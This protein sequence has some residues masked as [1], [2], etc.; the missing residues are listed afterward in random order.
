MKE[1]PESS[2]SEPLKQENLELTKAITT[3]A[4]VE[5]DEFEATLKTHPNAPQVIASFAQTTVSSEYSGPIPPPH[6]LEQYSRIDPNLVAHIITG[7][8]EE[9]HHRHSCEKAI[10][11]RSFSQTKRGQWLAFSIAIIG[12]AIGGFLAYTGKEIAGSILGGGGLVTIITAFLRKENDK[13]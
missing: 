7:S 3:L 1:V 5:R 13:D 12:I 6:L 4:K 9:R 8:K 2:K 11:D 10:I